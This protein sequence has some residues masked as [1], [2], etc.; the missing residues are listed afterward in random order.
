MLDEMEEE[1]EL[2]ALLNQYQSGSKQSPSQ[3]KA[4]PAPIYVPQYEDDP[5]VSSLPSGN[6]LTQE[7]FELRLREEQ[8]NFA[9][10]KEQ[11]IE[12]LREENKKLQEEQ[13]KQVTVKPEDGYANLLNSVKEQEMQQFQELMQTKCGSRV[14]LVEEMSM[15][16]E[17]MLEARYRHLVLLFSQNREGM[18]AALGSAPSE[19]DISSTFAHTNLQKATEEAKTPELPQ[20]SGLD[21]FLN[22]VLGTQETKEI[23]RMA[24]EKIA[25]IAKKAEE[26]AGNEDQSFDPYSARPENPFPDEDSESGSS[27][28]SYKD[29]FPSP[30]TNEIRPEEESKSPMKKKRITDAFTKPLQL[31]LV[32][33]ENQES[34]SRSLSRSGKFRYFKDDFE[35]KELQHVPSPDPASANPPSPIKEPE[36]PQTTE[37]SA[38]DIEEPSKPQ[39]LFQVSR[40]LLQDIDSSG[41]FQD[42]VE[43]MSSVEERLG[44]R[45]EERDK[46]AVFEAL[47]RPFFERVVA[48]SMRISGV[49]V[50]QVV[51]PPVRI[52]APVQEEVKLPPQPPPTSPSIPASSESPLKSPE[53]PE[54]PEIRLFD[55]PEKPQIE[56]EEVDKH[57]LAD[58]I[59]KEL[60]KK[61]LQES[62]PKPISDKSMPELPPLNFKQLED[63]E[64]RK[65]PT[66]SKAEIPEK[67][68]S[69]HISAYLG[70]IFHQAT[71]SD[72][73]Q[74]LSTAISF[75]AVDILGQL[76]DIEQGPLITYDL[77]SKSIIPT[78]VY[79]SLDEPGEG[80]SS[81]RDMTPSTKDIIRDSKRFHNKLVF[82]AVN[83]ALQKYRPYGLKGAPLPWSTNVR[84]LAPPLPQLHKIQE[85]VI[86]EVAEWSTF[87]VGKIPEGEIILSS[88]QV[89]EEQLQLIREERLS[90]MLTQ[91]ILENDQVWVD[92]EAEEAQVKID[93]AD[94]IL[95]Q[96]MTEIEDFL[97]GLELI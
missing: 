63:R 33:G 94:M 51:T 35:G 10:I 77:Q 42:D 21:L 45:W 92:Y 32:T 69:K 60:W 81:R 88:G 13:K 18:Q 93:I 82:D 87:E 20:D 27:L 52:P 85:K 41:S 19:M 59:Y 67:V 16:F 83:E 1:E 73:I 97:H 14:D 65:F 58:E 17:N 54:I 9:R 96:I 86:S 12:R 91:E 74:S 80:G 24:Q 2:P 23:E 48:E 62:V 66:K 44:V 34:S 79:L 49:K 70:K 68:N 39:G 84:A 76:Q 57:V 43:D 5:K 7:E 31:Q 36:R 46:N 90:K 22:K 15:A 78:E 61:L 28:H 71:T 38:K 72:I 50:A 25:E 95:E 47:Y 64:E 75:D 3:P 30:T 55:A 40:H 89:D 26:Q 37:G 29:D 6:H 11:E 56:Q 8:L 53:I 4:R